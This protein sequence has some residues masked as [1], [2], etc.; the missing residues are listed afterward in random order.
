LFADFISS[1]G[2]NIL[3]ERPRPYGLADALAESSLNYVA[4]FV[5]M[6]GTAA[7]NGLGYGLVTAAL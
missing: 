2:T 5:S 7:L 3:C 4:I 1:L 6:I